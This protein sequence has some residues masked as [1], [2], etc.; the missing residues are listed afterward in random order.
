MNEQNGTNHLSHNSNSSMRNPA[1]Q[2]PL[3]KRKQQQ[4]QLQQQLLLKQQLQQQQLQLGDN[5]QNTPIPQMHR[6]ES[7]VKP[8]WQNV[9]PGEVPYDT[10]EKLNQLSNG[11]QQTILLHHQQVN[12]A[13]VAD[14]MNKNKNVINDKDVN[15]QIIFIS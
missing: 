14:M 3:V 6:R 13:G 8:T 9:C 11:D 7:L 10:L 2:S 15:Y 12:G 1:F 5:P 4:Q